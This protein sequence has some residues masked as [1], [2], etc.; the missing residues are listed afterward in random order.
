MKKFFNYLTIGVF[1]LFA[2]TSCFDSDEEPAAC[3]VN[4]TAIAL[5]E[6]FDE[7]DAVSEDTEAT[8]EEGKSASQKFLDYYNDN[9]SCIEE[10]ID[11]ASSTTEEAEKAKEEMELAALLLE[12]TLSV[13]CD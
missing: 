2:L 7:F 4:A 10:T 3:D 8:C 5:E 1:S 12:L 9:K 6:A 11:A 13:S